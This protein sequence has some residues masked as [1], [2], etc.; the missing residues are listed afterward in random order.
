MTDSEK[1]EGE[2]AIAVWLDAIR[3]LKALDFSENSEDELVRL[4]VRSSYM[5]AQ[6]GYQYFEGQWVIPSEVN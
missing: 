2:I 5:L 6:L 4:I 1:A 3:C